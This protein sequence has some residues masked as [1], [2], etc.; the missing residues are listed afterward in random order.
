MLLL[1]AKLLNADGSRAKYVMLGNTTQALNGSAVFAGLTVKGKP[2]NTFKLRFTTQNGLAIERDLVLR[3]CQAGEHTATETVGG[4]QAQMCEACSA[5]SFSFY[6]KSE[7]CSQ[8]ANLTRNAVAVCN[9]AAVVPA[10]GFYQSHPRSPL[11]SNKTGQHDAALR[12]CLALHAQT[13]RA[14]SRCAAIMVLH[15]PLYS[16]TSA[17]A[18][19]PA[20]GLRPPSR[21]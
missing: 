18:Q 5:P 6:P 14:N 15:C 7:S 1:Q 9:R 2:G 17:S 16:F 19:A 20:C 4:E 12:A 8:C 10:N 11:V 3:Q 13:P 21:A